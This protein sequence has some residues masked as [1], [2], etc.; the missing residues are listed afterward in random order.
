MEESVPALTRPYQMTRVSLQSLSLLQLKVMM[1]GCGWML[2]FQT[3]ISVLVV[4]AV[5]FSD[6]I[7][8][9]ESY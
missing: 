1:G 2:Q 9:L 5:T 7:S 4:N 6:A 8:P 3:V